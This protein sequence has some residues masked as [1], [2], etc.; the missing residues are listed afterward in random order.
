MRRLLAI[1]TVI[2]AAG[3][4]LVV[5]GAGGGSQG[6][7]Y[8][9]VFDNAFGLVKGG[10][11]KVGGVKAGVIRD[12][13]LTNTEP[14]KVA[15]E[16]EITQPGFASLR[17]DAE[18]AVR[19][20]SLIGEY[21][22]DCQLGTARR[23]IP[24]GGTVPVKQ[25]SSTIPPDLINNVMRRPYRE[26]F[27]L[28][29]SELG[30]GLAGRPQELNEVIQASRADSIKAQWNRLPRF[31]GE[32]RPT[33]AQLEQTADEQIPFLR[34]MQGAAPHLERFLRELGPFADASRVSLRSLGRTAVI[35]RQALEESQEEIAQL[36][37][38]AEDAPRTARPL[39]QFLQTLDDRRRSTE[40]DPA[41]GGTASEGGG[42]TI[43][44]PP[45]DKTAYKPGQAHT[46]MENFW[47]YI[48]WQTLGTNGFDKVSHFLRILVLADEDC[49]PYS[50]KPEQARI[51]RCKSWA[52]KYQP[53]VTTNSLNVGGTDFCSNEATEAE[54][55][56]ETDK[57]ATAAD[58]AR[59]EAER[60]LPGKPDLSKPRV[61]LPPDLRDLL[62]KLPRLPQVPGVPGGVPDLPRA[63]GGDPV[64]GELLDY[65]LAP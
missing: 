55:P 30:V 19:N 6:T 43:A 32:L 13:R 17:T 46:G 24:D 7:R 54:N 22:V 35:G 18:C 38:L 65:L 39:R 21:F 14:R 47:N 51:D 58:K 2:G 5:T 12:F 61:T 45:P 37:E 56:T 34:R 36:R 27:R 44:P 53:C 26:R 9:V 63:R 60:P 29:I 40:N 41:A 64:P 57:R 11:L 62:D 31:L 15:V 48:Y 1:L 52:G 42:E 49:S 23:R 20:Q 50:A 4:A 16:V 33:L 28:I 8:D 3:L 59:E 25:T 10:D